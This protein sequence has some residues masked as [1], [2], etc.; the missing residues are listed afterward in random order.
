M[1]SSAKFVLLQPTTDVSCE[2]CCTC[3]LSLYFLYKIF[4]LNNTPLTTMA[5]D[6]HS[7]NPY[8][9]VVYVEKASK[10]ITSTH[11]KA[12]IL[13]IGLFFNKASSPPSSFIQK[14]G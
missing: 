4:I 14:W 9:H 5:T 1:K 12:Y 7:H 11:E 13:V 8:I 3:I 6:N 2:T 10:I